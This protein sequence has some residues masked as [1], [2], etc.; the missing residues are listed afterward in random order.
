MATNYPTSIDSFV[1]PTSSEPMTSPSH[2]G[3]HTNINDAVEAIETFVGT[4]GAP[5]FAPVASPAFTGSPTA[6]T[7]SALTNNTDLATTAYADAAVGVETSRAETAEALLAPKASPTFTGVV[8]TPILIVS[9]DQITATS[10]AA[11][12]PITNGNVEVTNSSSA[13]LTITL[14]T[15]GATR[16]QTLLLT[17]YDFAGTAETLT[18]VNTENS[19]ISVPTTTNGSTTLPLTVGF[20]FNGATSKWRCVGVA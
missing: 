15:S 1:D 17:I 2:S 4:T 8:T 9:A 19:T 7:K 16:G 20:R 14:A 13:T 5:N 12:V 3:Q 18:F 10:N 11:T 6:P